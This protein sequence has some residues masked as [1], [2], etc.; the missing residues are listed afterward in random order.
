MMIP[1]VILITLLF[2]G[3][4]KLIALSSLKITVFAV[5]FLL[6]F[7]YTTTFMHSEVSVKIS[8]GYVVYFWDIVFGILAMGIYGFLILL[9]HRLLP[10]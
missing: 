3:F 7:I 4:Y 2:I 9:I 5:D 6:I 8:S 10:I 1:A